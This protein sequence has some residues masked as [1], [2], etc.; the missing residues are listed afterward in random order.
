VWGVILVRVFF[1]KK[2]SIRLKLDCNG[3]ISLESERMNKDD[4]FSFQARIIRT[5][6][7]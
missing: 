6:K 2:Y 7:F 3:Y 4:L 5:D 1:E